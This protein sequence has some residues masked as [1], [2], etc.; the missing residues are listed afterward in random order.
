MFTK[1]FIL[2]VN[3]SQFQYLRERYTK[4]SSIYLSTNFIKYYKNIITI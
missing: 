1:Y 3:I 2:E 4:K